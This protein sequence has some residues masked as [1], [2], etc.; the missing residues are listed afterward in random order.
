[1]LKHLTKIESSEEL[2]LLL[3]NLY[4]EHLS[5]EELIESMITAKKAK[6][7]LIEHQD[8]ICGYLIWLTETEKEEEEKEVTIIKTMVVDEIVFMQ[9]HQ[10]VEVAKN[11]INELEN[12]AKEKECKSIE[13]TL[14]SQSF[15]LIPIFIQEGGFASS[16][17]RVSKEL[18]KKTEFVQI[19]NTVSKG[20]KPE[21]IE[22]MVSKNETYHLEIIEEPLDYRKIIEEGYN[23]EIVSMI[24]Y[25]EDEKMEEKLKQIN[26]IANWQE[27]SFSL[28][29]RL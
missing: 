5:I 25:V 3:E 8:E 21:I 28:I 24:F 27:Y 18:M 16:V 23:P 26:D 20:L 7:S 10:D 1:M 15:W 6:L 13:V 12:L 11:F 22:V 29:K 2:K 14:P 19:F 17:L 9:K 4:G